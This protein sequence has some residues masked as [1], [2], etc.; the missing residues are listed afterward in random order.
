MPLFF[1]AL[2]HLAITLLGYIGPEP[3]VT[4]ITYIHEAYEYNRLYADKITVIH[5]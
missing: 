3:C 4:H 5:N 2:C 1:K